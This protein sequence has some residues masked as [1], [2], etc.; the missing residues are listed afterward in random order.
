[1]VLTLTEAGRA[2]WQRTMALI[3]QRNQQIADCLSADEQATLSGLLDR[4]IEHKRPR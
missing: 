2:A 3:Q 4:L 1:V